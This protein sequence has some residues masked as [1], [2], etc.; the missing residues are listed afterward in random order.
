MWAAMIK[1][2]ISG[3]RSKGGVPGCDS[4]DAALASQGGHVLLKH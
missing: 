1:V 4:G 2:G 3:L